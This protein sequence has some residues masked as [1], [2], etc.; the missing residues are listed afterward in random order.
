MDNKVNGKIRIS[1]DAIASIAEVAANEIKGATA[2]N[3]MF[4]KSIKVSVEAGEVNIDIP[5]IINSEAVVPKVSKEVQEHVKSVVESTTG[6]SVG[7]VKI[8]VAEVRMK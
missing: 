5:V 7:D 1:N 8:I 2:I 4:G 3:R 6:L